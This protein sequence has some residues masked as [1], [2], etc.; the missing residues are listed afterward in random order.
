MSFPFRAVIFDM[1][2]LMLDTESISRLCWRKAGDDLG[3]EI[4]DEIFRGFVGRSGRDCSLM[5]RERWGAAFP[6]ENMWARIEHHWDEHV[7]ANGIP[8]KTGLMELLDFLDDRQIRKAVAT[9]SKRDHARAKLG[10]LVKRFDALATGDEVPRGKPAPDIFLL[11]AE[12]LGVP[13][14][15]CLVLEDSHAGIQ[16]A[17]AAGMF[18]LMV[19]DLLPSHEQAS[20]V[21]QSLHEVQAWLEAE[22]KSRRDA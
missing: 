11:A 20:H 21:C 14:A 18:A 10:A 8:H 7:A 6:C 17:R 12:R 15:A 19:P 9:S 13:A 2:G 1:D 5:L 22:A 3:Y 4:T 16:G